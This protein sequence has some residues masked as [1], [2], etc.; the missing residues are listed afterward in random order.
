M[1]K[2]VF[3]LTFTFVMTAILFFSGIRL[4]AMVEGY[5]TREYDSLAQSP[6]ADTAN[7]D[8]S[9][10]AT[11]GLHRELY[12]F[13]VG[14]DSSIKGFDDVLRSFGAEKNEPVNI[15]IL[16]NDDVS[17]NMD[18]IIILH[19]DPATSQVNMMSVPRDTYVTVKGLKSHKINSVFPSTD[20]STRLKTVLQDM[21]GQKIDYYIHLNLKTVREIIDL[22]DGVD[23]FVPCDMKYDD[24]DQK[25]HI[26]LKKGQQLLNGDKVEQL[27][28][29]RHPNKGGWTKEIEKYYGGGSDIN[30]ITRQQDFLNEMIKQKL[31]IQ[32]V[33]KI[34]DI[35][36]T[37]YANIKTDLPL[38]EMLKL[39]RGVVGFSPEKFQTVMIPGEGKYVDNISYFI[40]NEKLTLALAE[41]L[42]SS[43]PK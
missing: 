37:V 14:H 43:S 31:T 21:V 18:S 8:S 38:T 2:T 27:L 33:P 35:I 41:E 1:K 36:N 10:T 26:N 5:G 13:L 40:H 32:Y 3:L 24:P 16:V 15:L 17:V 9:P 11:G 30:R 7:D 22:L 4:L 29:F 12:G 39:A 6:G 20:G 34:T 19:F 23:Y 28:R 25:L 42:L